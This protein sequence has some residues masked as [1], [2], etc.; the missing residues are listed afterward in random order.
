M[1]RGNLFSVQKNGNIFSKTVIYI[2]IK[3]IWFMFIADSIIIISE[4]G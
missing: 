3:M 1:Y 4:K 2:K